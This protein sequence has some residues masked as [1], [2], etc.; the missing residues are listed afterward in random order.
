[1]VFTR[2]LGNCEGRY[3][4]DCNVSTYM[5]GVHIAFF[6]SPLT[7]WDLNNRLHLVARLLGEERCGCRITFSLIGVREDITPPP[8]PSFITRE[9]N[10]E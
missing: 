1:M 10:V 3:K 6:H 9:R 4:E 7:Q 8:P 5:R 2:Q